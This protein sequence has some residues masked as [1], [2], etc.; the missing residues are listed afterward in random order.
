MEGSTLGAIQASEGLLA[1]IHR[2]CK[3]KSLD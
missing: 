1:V 3:S 2:N